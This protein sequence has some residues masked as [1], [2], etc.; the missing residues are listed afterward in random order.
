MEIDYI[1]GVQPCNSLFLIVG[2]KIIIVIM[3]Q[4]PTIINF[5]LNNMLILALAIAC[6]IVIVIYIIDWYLG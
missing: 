4:F 3:Q 5:K 1:Q 2:L 6:V